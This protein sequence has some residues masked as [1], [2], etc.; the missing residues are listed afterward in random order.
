MVSKE[1]RKYGKLVEVLNLKEYEKLEGL[2]KENLPRHVPIEIEREEKKGKI[3]L[4]SRYPKVMKKALQKTREMYKKYGTDA[5]S[6]V[7]LK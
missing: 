1:V 3:E 7:E 4:W 2:L 6:K 5:M